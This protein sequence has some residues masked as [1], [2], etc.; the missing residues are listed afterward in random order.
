[1]THARRQLPDWH[2]Q[3]SERFSLTPRGSDVS[4]V[5]HGAWSCSRYRTWAAALLCHRLQGM[6]RN[7]E[8]WGGRGAHIS[9]GNLSV[10]RSKVVVICSLCQG[11]GLHKAA[12]LYMRQELKICSRGEQ[13]TYGKNTL[14]LW[15]DASR[16]QGSP[17]AEGPQ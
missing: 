12:A 11:F 17:Q 2:R 5:A 14:L 10:A 13:S 1:M 4:R 9:S 7:P 6:Q 8:P 3:G 16:S 15:R